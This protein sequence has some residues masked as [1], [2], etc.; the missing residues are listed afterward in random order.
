MRGEREGKNEREGAASVEGSTLSGRALA[1]L[2][3][4]ALAVPGIVAAAHADT[5]IDQ[6][7]AAYAFSAY[8]ED[9]LAN[10]KFSGTGS[11]HRYEVLTH[12]LDFAV[13]VSKRMD[14]GAQFLYEKMSGASPWYVEASGTE[15]V[16]VMSGATIDDTRYD[17]STNL[18]YY[19][20]DAKDT[21]TGGFSKEQDYLSVNGG[22]GTE[23]SFFDKNTTI[24][25]S[26]AFSYDWIK[27]NNPGLS[28]AR[29]C[30]GEKWSV[31]LFAGLSQLITRASAIQFTANYK[32]SNGY[33]SDPYKAIR[34]IGPADGLLSD[35]RPDQKEQG[36]LMVRYR[37]HF[38]MTE[39]IGGTLHLDYRF[40]ADDWSVS[41]HTFELAWYQS[42]GPV[43]IVP[44]ARYYS[45]S[46]ADFYDTLLPAGAAE[47]D[48]G[49]RSSDFRLSPYGAIS[50]KVKAELA[51]DDVLAYHPSGKLE[52]VGIS[53]GLDLH[54]SAAYERYISD[55]GFGLKSVSSK[56]E[57][58]GLVSFQ[59][60]S[61][62]LSGRF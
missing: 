11:Q 27:P 10:S 51:L 52:N 9:D 55:G 23:R 18:N 40:Y 30:C 60:F 8:L 6:A 45:Q 47:N 38:D 41:S 12:Q 39:K 26:G 32:H 48:P 22:L 46:K 44:G 13:P 36:S 34:G 59:I 19:M 4:S 28:L 21:F 14:A 20:E 49:N 61:V 42:F 37:H 24:S 29:P 58:P 1:A 5:P 57:A 31:D 50:W 15:R 53:G 54:L 2:T 56:D 35:R 7:S 25:A 16:Q 43:T 17:L 3:T 62:S 33:L